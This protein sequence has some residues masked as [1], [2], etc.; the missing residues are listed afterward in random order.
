MQTDELIHIL[1]ADVGDAPR[2][3]GRSLTIA[4][5]IGFAVSAI[6]FWITLGPRTDIAEAAT[7][8]RFD[9]K[10][11][12]MLVLAGV[13]GALV[14]RLARPGADWRTMSLLLLIVPAALATAAV[15]E[16]MLVGPQWQA[17]LVGSN[18]LVC[19]T[20][21]PLLSLPLLL[22][23]LYALRQSAPTQPATAG[24]VAGLVA[25]GLAAA[26]YALQCTDDSPLFVATWYPIAIVAVSLLGAAMAQRLLRW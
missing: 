10:I 21:I 26:L 16:L 18:S 22:S 17:K 9:L 24:A 23:L 7:T 14:L 11:V 6:L 2:S 25:G 13:A 8:A 12:E 3:L 5:A 15:I 20:A 1:A 19:L 4:G